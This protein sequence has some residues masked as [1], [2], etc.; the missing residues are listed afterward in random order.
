MCPARAPALSLASASSASSSAAISA[1][2]GHRLGDGLVEIAGDAP[3]LSLGGLLTI[4]HPGAFL[5]PQVV[6]ENIDLV[7]DLLG[8]RYVL[9]AIEAG[10]PADEVEDAKGPAARAEGNAEQPAEP[11]LRDHAVLSAQDPRVGAEVGGDQRRVAE[12]DLSQP[13]LVERDQH[14]LARKGR[15][16]RDGEALKG[17]AVAGQQIDAEPIV[18]EQ[19]L[20]LARKLSDHPR[21]IAG[22]LEAPGSQHHISAGLEGQQGEAACDHRRHPLQHLPVI[23]AAV[24]LE[25]TE[26]GVVG[27][28]ADQDGV[29]L[30]GDRVARLDRPVEVAR[31]HRLEV[32]VG[33]EPPELIEALRRRA[34]DPNARLRPELLQGAGRRLAQLRPI[35]G[36][37]E[38]G[39]E[40]SEGE[41]TVLRQLAF[42]KPWWRARCRAPL[43]SGGSQTLLLLFRGSYDGRGAS[44]P[45]VRPAVGALSKV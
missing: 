7:G 43:G 31:R 44:I 45:S 29:A 2:S 30:S 11:G 24:H 37:V 26:D 16:G 22:V 6:D 32:V 36:E 3:P 20:G 14:P 21:G 19:A 23:R 41:E 13:D 27:A 25:N 5:N 38:A 33:R 34:P 42:E 15:G 35:Q 8:D 9:L 18:V 4:H 40:P 28:E 1:I 17:A 12:H 39:G 10:L